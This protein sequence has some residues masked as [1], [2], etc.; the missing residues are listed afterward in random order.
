M[1]ESTGESG[2]YHAGCGLYVHIPFCETKCGYCDFF[3]EPVRGRDTGSL[4]RRLCHELEKRVSQAPDKIRTI[5]CGGGTPTILPVEQLAVVLDV[6]S[7][8]AVR[9]HVA[10]FTVEVNPATVDDEKAR[11]LVAGGVSRVSMGAQSFI[12]EELATL[13]RL[14]TPDDVGPS[15]RTLRRHGVRQ[16]S[17]DLIFS[18]PGQTL[19]T[20]SDS[21]RRAIDLQ[22]D[23]I[24]A[25]GLTYEPGTRLTTQRQQ[26]LVASCDEQLEAEMYLLAMDTLAEAGFEQ[27]EISNFARPGCQCRH[28]LIYWR[29]GPYIGVGPSAA[30]CVDRRRYKNVAD[31]DQYVRMID[32]LGHAEV[33]TET[34][35]TSMVIT[36]MIMLQLRLV[37]GLNLAHFR[38]ETG[39]EPLE[40]LGATAEQSTRSGDDA[41]TVADGS[42]PADPRGQTRAAD[43]MKSRLV[44]SPRGVGETTDASYTCGNPRGLKPAARSGKRE[45]VLVRLT[46][47]GLVTVSDTHI[48]LTQEGRLKAD[49][50]IAELVNACSD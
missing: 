47:L 40:L 32:E 26:G 15:V 24:S 35:D 4:V 2:G 37:E 21:L 7:R 22:V 3:S 41:G 43:R 33:E 30:G 10:E 8:V 50:V 6:L 19:A 49:A 28:N 27:Y 45:D 5:F 38:R 34:L 9:D 18:V 46:N 31:V 11:L 44:G 20:W 13:E 25:Y 1:T 42:A 12:A 48:A 29:N 36:E 39:V 23:H 14:H 16:V 17:L